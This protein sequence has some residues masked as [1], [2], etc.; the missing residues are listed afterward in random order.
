MPFQEAQCEAE[1]GTCVDKCGCQG[2]ILH[3]FCPSQSNSIKCC[4][5]GDTSTATNN[6][7]SNS[8]EEC[9]EPSVSNE[10]GQP[11]GEGNAKPNCP[12][13]YNTNCN[14]GV[15]T[16]TC[17]GRGGNNNNNNNNNG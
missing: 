5:K 6:T 3:G 11:N 2:E 10:G 13:G 16:V 4:K 17:S 7:A 1:G 9:E 14:N 12:G 8:E 15:C